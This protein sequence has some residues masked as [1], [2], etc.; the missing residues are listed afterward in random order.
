[1]LRS[2]IVVVTSAAAL[3]GASAAL[4]HGPAAHAA[5]SCSVGSGEH[6]YGYTYLF[7]IKVSHTGCST[8]KNV[9]KHHGHVRGWHCSTKTLANS[10][11]QVQARETC[12]SGRKSVVWTYSQNK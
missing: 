9:V 6:V 8:G 11:T 3:L 5:A 1:V 12:T 7:P 4:A 10:P 2:M